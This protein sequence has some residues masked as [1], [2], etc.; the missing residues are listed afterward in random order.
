METRREFLE[1]VA[2]VGGT[3]GLAG[4]GLL[5]G[6]FLD[7]ALPKLMAAEAAIKGKGP[8][9]AATEEA[10]W[11]EVQDAYAVDR[12]IINLNN[13]GVAP[14]PRVVLDAFRRHVELSN[15]A[16]AYT[17]WQI[18]EPEIESVRR[19]LARR[20][21]C[22][23]E[24][25]AVTRNASEALETVLLGL[26][27]KAGDEVL[28]TAQDYPRML[29]TLDQRARRE[30]IVVRKISFPTPPRSLE[31]LWDL[32]ARSV[33]ARTR[34][35]LLCHI[36]NLTGQIFPV[37]EIARMAHSR[38]IDVVVDGAHAF[39]HLV[40]GRDDLECDFYG[41]SL[42][43][44]LSAPIG[45]GFL[46]VR[47]DKIEKVWPLMAAPAEMNGNIR[48]FEEIGTHP[49]ATHNAIAEALTFYET[50]GAERKLA[51]LRLL[52]DR[53]MRRLEGRSGVILRTSFDPSMSGA[54][55]N[56]A[57]EGVD[58]G[59]LASHLW[60]KR[61]ILV[62]AITHEECPGIRV[63][64]NVYT[65]LDEIDQF[66]EAMEKVIREGLPA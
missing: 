49:A 20:F 54:L 55:G 57:L 37:R 29:T 53:W 60:E 24:E 30:G 15:S 21:G 12:N 52:R 9:E 41:T 61:R 58:P 42:H 5:A 18:L 28:T 45:T 63:T 4:S 39:A 10:F 35:I 1:H 34:A 26:D 17:M 14:A 11:R 27:L 36:T 32:F 44:W 3:A 66:S 59:K 8:E 40:Y 13:G 46:Y 33:T 31:D 56:V 6:S 62:T 64:P 43:K 16:P 38:G 25:I 47:K 51:R 50:L 22:D 23:P 2:A 19:S 7:G 48:K 65:T